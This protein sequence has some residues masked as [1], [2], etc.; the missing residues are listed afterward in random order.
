MTSFTSFFNELLAPDRRIEKFT[1][2]GSQE[3]KRQRL[4]TEGTEKNGALWSAA[5]FRRS[6]FV[7]L[8]FPS[9][10]EKFG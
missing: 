9:M 7:R 4:N 10:T 1:A 6:S 2:D 3:K 8:Q 5:A